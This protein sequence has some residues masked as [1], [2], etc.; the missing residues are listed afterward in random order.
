MQAKTRIA[1]VI[2]TA[3][4]SLATAASANGD[5]FGLTTNGNL[6]SFRPSDPG[7]AGAT[8]I[9]GPISGFTGTDT[10]LVGIDFRP[11]DRQLYGVGNAGGIYRISKAN[12][13]LTAVNTL[14]T[15]LSGT[16]FGVDF[17]PAAD[18]LRIIGDAGQNL[19]HNVNAGGTTLN[20]GS[21][22]Y[23]AT[24]TPGATVAGIGSAAYTNNDLVGTT[25]TTLFNIDTT[26]DQ[27]TVQVPPNTGVQTA[28]GQL[29]TDFVLPVGFDIRSV[30][31]NSV[32]IGHVGFASTGNSLFE[33]N[34]L[35]GRATLRGN[36]PM[37][38][39]D[40]AFEILP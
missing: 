28:V 33:I 25:G 19:R 35:T 15:A 24:L 9:R 7:A 27:V 29:G 3:L 18:R 31:N 12:G 37:A 6:I 26:L 22:N 10:A 32:T 11:Q 1:S 14:S 36:F 2:A 20:D 13:T 17:N 21:L 5:G 30:R 40:I 8:T 34:L 38:V 4:F 16:N 23:T 39:T